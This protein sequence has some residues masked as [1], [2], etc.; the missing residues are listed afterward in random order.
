M[1]RTQ[2]FALLIVLCVG[3]VLGLGYSHIAKPLEPVPGQDK[4]DAELAKIKALQD[5]E[6]AKIQALAQSEGRK[7]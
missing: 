2:S 7:P 5:R 6:S 1:K 3:F 4:L